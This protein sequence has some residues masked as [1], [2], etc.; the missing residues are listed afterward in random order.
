[1]HFA[2]WAVGTRQKFEAGLADCIV[3]AWL[4]DDIA[5]IFVTDY[6][7]AIIPFILTSGSV[8]FRGSLFQPPLLEIGI[9]LSNKFDAGDE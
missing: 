2:V 7:V 5:H 8:V 6:T 3:Q 1:M 4:E 9:E